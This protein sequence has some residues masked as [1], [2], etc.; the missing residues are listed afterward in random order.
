MIKYS[1]EKITK[2]TILRFS[3]RSIKDENI[4]NLVNEGK[5]INGSKKAKETYFQIGSNLFSSIGLFMIIV[6]LIIMAVVSLAYHHMGYWNLFLY[7]PSWSM[8]II[9]FVLGM[10]ERATKENKNVSFS[11]INL[12][13]SIFIGIVIAFITASAGR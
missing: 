2:Y 4:K 9:G 7:V 1:S 6:S 8:F 3:D 10:K 5:L 13:V 11:T 12:V